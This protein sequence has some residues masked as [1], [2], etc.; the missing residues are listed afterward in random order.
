MNT[1]ACLNLPGIHSSAAQ[2]KQWHKAL[3]AC[4]GKKNANQLFIMQYDKV[5]L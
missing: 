2:W 4:V 5:G 1:T 3:K